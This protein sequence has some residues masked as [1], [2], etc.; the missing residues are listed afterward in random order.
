MVAIDKIE[1]IDIEKNGNTYKINVKFASQQINYTTDKENKII[2]GSKTE[3]VK[4]VE[5]W[6]FVRNI[7]SKNQTWFI[8]KIEEV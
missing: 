1:I 3:I 4:V 2:D 7:L 5:K 6:T 8:E